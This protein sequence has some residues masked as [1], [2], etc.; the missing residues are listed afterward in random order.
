[1]FSEGVCED[2]TY[3]QSPVTTII[4]SQHKLNTFLGKTSKGVGGDTGKEDK[5][6][7]DV[8]SLG[9]VLLPNL[10]GMS[11]MA[12]LMLLEI[13]MLSRGSKAD[14]RWLIH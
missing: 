12:M 11:P 6:R 4:T 3:R 9:K 1:M 7:R 5:G 8:H 2:Q 13:Q 10:Q 14:L